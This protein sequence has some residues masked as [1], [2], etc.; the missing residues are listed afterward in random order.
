M[1][2]EPSYLC[3]TVN[4]SSSRF[5]FKKINIDHCEEKTVLC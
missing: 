4:T 1:Q 3:N 2:K 5:F